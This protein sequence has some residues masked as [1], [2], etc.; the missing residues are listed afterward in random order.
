MHTL[1]EVVVKR[2]PVNYFAINAGFVIGEFTPTDEIESI[3][4]I[5]LDDF[6]KAA[7]TKGEFHY[8]TLNVPALAK[9]RPTFTRT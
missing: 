5:T 9:F 6:A 2:R 1:G 7:A 8:S 3:K 4:F